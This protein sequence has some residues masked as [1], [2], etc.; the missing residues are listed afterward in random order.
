MEKDT[1]VL[2]RFDGGVV[3]KGKIMGER[4]VSVGLGVVE[5]GIC[6]SDVK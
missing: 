3:P 2:M 5:K 4:F 1:L 6:N